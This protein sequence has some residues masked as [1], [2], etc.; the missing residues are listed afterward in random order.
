MYVYFIFFSHLVKA[1]IRQDE[2][3]DYSR[4]LAAYFK[5]NNTIIHKNYVIKYFSCELLNFS[6]SVS[7]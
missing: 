7:N 3:R 5:S 4:I 1:I 2:S 6:I